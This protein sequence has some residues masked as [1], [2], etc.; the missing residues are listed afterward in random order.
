MVSAVPRGRMISRLAHYALRTLPPRTSS[1]MIIH[2]AVC[3][4]R[5]FF[6]SALMLA[7]DDVMRALAWLRGDLE[8]ATNEAAA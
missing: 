6:S 2:P 4:I 1:P 5:L 8:G 3:I 7:E